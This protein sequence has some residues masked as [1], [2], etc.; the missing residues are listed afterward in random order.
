MLRR[1]MGWYLAGYLAFPCVVA[2]L[3]IVV[4][5]LYLD[6]TRFYPFWLA[7]SY[8]YM[9]LPAVAI[10]AWRVHWGKKHPLF[11]LLLTLGLLAATAWMGTQNLLEY[12]GNVVREHVVPLGLAE[13]E[14]LTTSGKY[15]IP[16]FPYD[17]NRL[18]DAIG[19]RETVEVWAVEKKGLIIAFTDPAFTSYTLVDRLLELGLGLLALAVFAIFFWVVVGIWS[20][21][22]QVKKDYVQIRRWGKMT[23]IPLRN[24]IHVQLDRRGEEIRLETEEMV[25]N[26][27]FEE[28]GAREVAAAAE[29]TGLLPLRGGRRWVQG[30]QYREL[31]LEKERLVFLGDD[32]RA[33]PYSR[34]TDLTWDP[35]IQ[36]TMD[37][38]STHTITDERYLDRSWFDELTA[39]VKA[40]WEESGQNYWIQVEPR[41]GAVTLALAEE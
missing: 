32:E 29:R 31:R 23:L 12:K 9:G 33:I 41:T 3:Y 10:L 22:M 7:E 26:F 34:M 39:R 14:L 40:S 37:D 21:E 30:E 5:Q 17:K 28:E 11:Y 15:T 4:Y 25:Y 19:E 13:G 1:W 38:E 6:S 16:Y 24:L 8:F 27:P 18:V 2:L 36:I 20:R 35:L